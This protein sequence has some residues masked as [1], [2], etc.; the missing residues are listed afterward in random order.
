[1]SRSF[2]F[3][4]P[5]REV[6]VVG[7]L[8]VTPDSFSDGGR[9]V[10]TD[11]AV[12]HALRLVADGAHLID[13]GGEST[14]PGAAPVEPDEEARRVVPVIE[15]LAGL[16]IAMSVDT[17]RPIVA[18]RAIDAGAC[19][20]NDVSGLRDQEMLG[21]IAGAAVPVIVM[22]APSG[23][24]IETHRH[25]GYN[26]VV[27]EVVAFLVSQVASAQAA[28]ISDVVVDPGIGFGK[29]LADNVSLLRRLDELGPIGCPV[30]V[31]ASRKR[32]LGA[33]SGVDE[34]VGRDAAS[35]AAHLLAVQRGATAI[36]VHD[37]AGHVQALAVLRAV[38]HAPDRV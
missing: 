33:L 34:P 15:A 5:D 9:Y 12:A 16:G 26:D 24:M 4:S 31:G 25:G 19:V 1:M 22:H 7:I 27:A 32:F 38:E 30:L 21:V 2:S 13:V 6:T 20:V 29:S 3:S 11:R 10:D 14:R 36:R 18:R 8:N 35:I 23:D 37:V 17:R 28:G